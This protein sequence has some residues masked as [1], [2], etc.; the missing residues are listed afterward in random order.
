MNLRN[1]IEKLDAENKLVRIKKEVSTDFEIANLLAAL[2]GR[3]VLFEKVKG[4]EFPVIGNLVS[5]GIWSLPPLECRRSSCWKKW[6][7]R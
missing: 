1:F 4:S 5:S 3:V 2:D 7:T 6:H